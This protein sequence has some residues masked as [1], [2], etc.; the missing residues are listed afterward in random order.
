MRSIEG[1]LPGSEGMPKKG[2][3]V[4]VENADAARG[5]REAEVV[6]SGFSSHVYRGDMVVEYEDGERDLVP[7][8]RV[9]AIEPRAAQPPEGPAEEP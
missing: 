9:R 6:A 2:E 5:A 4:I 7:A 3:A 1:G 8:S